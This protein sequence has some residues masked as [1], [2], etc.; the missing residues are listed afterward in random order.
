MEEANIAPAADP[1]ARAADRAIDV[2]IDVV[3][4]SANTREMTL[5]CVSELTHPLLARVIVVDN[6]S[7][8]GTAEAIAERFGERVQ[9]VRLDRAVGF[10]A[11]CNR[12][13]ERGSAPYVL[14]LN[15][16]ILLT[17][18][19]I[20]GLLEAL[21]GYPGAVA[22]GGRLVDPED[23]STQP[24]YRPR[25]F[26]TLADFAVILLGLEELWPGNPITRRY[27]GAELDDSTTRVVE[28]PAAAALLVT[29]PA[30]LAVGGFDERFWFWFEDS[31][32][33]AR[34]SRRGSVLYVPSA[35]FKHLGGGT[36]RRWSKSDRIRSAHHGIVRYGEAHFSR[37]QRA[38][39]GALVLAVSVPR[40]VLFGRSRPQEAQAWRAVARGGRAL[41][42]DRPAPAIAPGP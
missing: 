40:V 4:V 26:P 29:R 8:D 22:A 21:R 14:F 20:A 16:D 36:F 11:A 24:Q 42:L 3:I 32:L 17:P 6:G 37:A 18:G 19:A 25:R 13:A 33:L 35:A 31:D 30:L 12:G 27:H 9:V 7:D 39:L 1:T 15:S 10:A 2:A 34:L 23:L 5:G 28:Q 38:L 41:L